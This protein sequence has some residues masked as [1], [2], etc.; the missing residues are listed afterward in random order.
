MVETSTVAVFAQNG[1][2]HHWINDD[3]DQ[4]DAVINLDTG[5]L[6]LTDIYHKITFASAH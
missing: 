6:S 2:T 4:L 5:S 3:Y 1:D